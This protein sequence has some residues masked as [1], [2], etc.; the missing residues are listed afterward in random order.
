MPPW[1]LER[2]GALAL[3][4]T[5]AMGS[6][7]SPGI[8]F[9]SSAPA[10]SAA[11]AATSPDKQAAAAWAGSLRPDMEREAAAVRAAAATRYLARKGE[12]ARKGHCNKEDVGVE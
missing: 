5:V 4:K 1:R 7:R 2:P 11:T 8:D 6:L 12:T 9:F 10:P 3:E